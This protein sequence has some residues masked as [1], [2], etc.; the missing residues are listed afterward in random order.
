[1][2]LG[3]K[4]DQFWYL[5][6]NFIKFKNGFLLLQKIRGRLLKIRYRQ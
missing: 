2:R 3:G 1:M 6:N 4:N 5:S